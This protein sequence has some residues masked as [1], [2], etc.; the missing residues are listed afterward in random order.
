VTS[1]TIF[2]A[3]KAPPASAT[4]AYNFCNVTL[5]PYGQSGDR[6]YAWGGGYLYGVDLVTYERSGC[7]TVSDGSGNL[8]QSWTCFPK[9]SSPAAYELHW[10]NDGVYRKPVIRNNNLSYSGHFA[11]AYGC[12]YPC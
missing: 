11:G 8:I 6:C 5:A 3:A 7:S 2:A 9:G 12:F 10:V 4:T 1:I